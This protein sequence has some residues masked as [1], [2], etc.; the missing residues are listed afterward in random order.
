[1][2]II[3]CRAVI[4]DNNSTN[5]VGGSNVILKET[6]AEGNSYPQG[7]MREPDMVNKANN[8][9]N[10][11]IYLISFLLSVS[12]KRHKS[13][14][15]IIITVME[16]GMYNTN[17]R[18]MGKHEHNCIGITFLFITGIKFNISLL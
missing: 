14:N 15:I 11:N 17:G 18:K 3:T 13:Y 10:I 5:E 8:T 4:F 9:N 1:M 16:Y 6:A 12:L 7:K 2:G